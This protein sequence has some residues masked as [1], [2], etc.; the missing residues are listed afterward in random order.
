MLPNILKYHWIGGV[1]LVAQWWRICPPRQETRV[2]SLVQEDPACHRAT[3]PMHHSWACALESGSHS[4]WSLHPWACDLHRE[5]LQQ[6]DAGAQQCKECPQLTATIEECSNE[7]PAPKTNA[8]KKQKQWTGS[9]R[10]TSHSLGPVNLK[11][12]F[13]LTWNL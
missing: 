2:W 3:K 9:F 6:R 8:F 7:D 4:Y 12:E 5:K 11:T 10:F 1:P 13:S